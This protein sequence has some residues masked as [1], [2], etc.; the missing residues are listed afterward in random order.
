MLE[1]F[2]DLIRDRDGPLELFA[3]DLRQGQGSSG[4][5]MNDVSFSRRPFESAEPAEDLGLV[6]MS[7]KAVELFYSR[8]HGHDLA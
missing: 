4:L 3:D 7:R 2:L 8:P 1:I 6:G 5:A